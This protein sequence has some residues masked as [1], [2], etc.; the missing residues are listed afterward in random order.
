MEQVHSGICE[1]GWSD[2]E[3]VK[4]FSNESLHS[5]LLRVVSRDLDIHWEIPTLEVPW[6]YLT[7]SRFK[8]VDL[9]PQIFFRNIW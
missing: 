4:R 1:L 3:G 6:W 2:D 9:L 8:M 7:K 5:V